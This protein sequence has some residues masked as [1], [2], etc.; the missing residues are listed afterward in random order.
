MSHVCLLFFS[1]FRFDS[2]KGYGFITPDTGAADI[3]VHQSAIYAEGFRSLAE[4]EK[5]EF[6]VAVENSKPKAVDVTGPN[7][8]AVQGAPFRQKPQHQPGGGGGYP[9]RQ[10]RRPNNT[11]GEWRGSAGNYNSGY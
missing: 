3:F 9:Q 1:V 5:V 7:G 11:N 6:N 2:Q 10:Q 8:A 4:G